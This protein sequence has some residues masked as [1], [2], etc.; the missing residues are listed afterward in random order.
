MSEIQPKSVV[1][2][3]DAGPGHRHVN[4]VTSAIAASVPTWTQVDSDGRNT[5]ETVIPTDPAVSGLA[6]V[7]MPNYEP[8]FPVPPAGFAYLVNGDGSYILNADGAYILAK[9]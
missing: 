8:P 2:D 7:L 4:I 6:T 1:V 5:F 9:V 3:P